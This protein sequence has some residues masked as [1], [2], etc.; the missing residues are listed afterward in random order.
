MCN[1]VPEIS[2]LF[3]NSSMNLEDLLQGPLRNQVLGQ[4]SQQ[5][6][7]DNQ[8][9][10]ST[11]LDSTLQVLLNAV[12]KNVSK[13]DGASSLINA[14]NK[15][16]DG[17]ILDNV[18]DFLGGQFQPQNA[19]TTNGIG[20]L[21]HLLGDKQDDAAKTIGQQ[22]GMD[23][24]QIM[25]M[26]AAVA[27]ILMGVLGKANQQSSSGPVS[28]GGGL[29]DMVLST[30]KKVNQQSNQGS[31]LTQFLDKDGDGSIMDDVAGMGFKA[32][33]G[34]LFKRK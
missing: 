32:I 2:I 13:P 30:T 34:R 10:A 25:K 28:G 21:K 27:P 14:L 1:I 12:S 8:Q 7:V 4:L 19:S 20:I 5:L 11:A 26:M 23:A 18:S 22:S 31:I 33:V 16:H 15:D 6:N 29:I 24:G 9:Q 3:K 17:S